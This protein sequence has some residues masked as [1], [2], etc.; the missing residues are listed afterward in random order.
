MI[1]INNR[2]LTELK[3]EF[4]GINSSTLSIKGLIQIAKV[5][6]ANENNVKNKSI[7]KKLFGNVQFALKFY[8]F[9]RMIFSENN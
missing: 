4:V 1:I 7:Y 2:K 8:L 9:T 3:V 5:M 6:S